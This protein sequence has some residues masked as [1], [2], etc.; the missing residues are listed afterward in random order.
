VAL[1]LRA[2]LLSAL[3]AHLCAAQP[4][5]VAPGVTVEQV[6]DGAGPWEV[7]VIRIERPASQAHLV[8]ALGGGELRGLEALSRIIRR[9]TAD[10]A[11]VVAAV[12]A[13]FF[14]MSGPYAGG[15][16]GPCV[17]NGELVTT[18]RGRPGFFI[19]ADGQPLI[20]TAHT[21]G[22]L[23]VAGRSYPVDGANMPDQGGEGAVQLFT[24]IGGWR[25]GEGC[26]VAALEG[27]PLRTQ[28]SWVATVTEVAPA[29]SARAAG[30]GEVLIAARD[31]Q[32][33]AALLG[34]RPGD[35]VAIELRTPPFTAPVLQAVGGSTVLVQDGAVVAADRVRHPRTAAGY[36]AREI[37]LVTVD[38]RQPRWSV[39]MTMT[40]LAGLMHRL[41]CTDAV[42]LDGGGSTTA[43]AHRDLLGRPSDGRQRRIA[44]ALL[45]V[46]TAPRGDPVA[47][48]VLPARATLLSGAGLPLALRLTDAWHCPLEVESGDIRAEVV[49]QA[50]AAPVTARLDGD[51]LVVEGGPGRA[52]VR[53]AHRDARRAATTVQVEVV[54]RAEAL[55]LSPVDLRLRAGTSAR[56]DARAL[57][58]EGTRLLLPREAITW[59][60]EG[61]GVRHLGGGRFRADGE[62]ARA[63]VTA[64]LDGLAAHARVRS[65][66][67]VPVED[68]ADAPAMSFRGIPETVTG[69]LALLT[70]EHEGR[71]MGFVRMTYDLGEPT[72][73]RAAYVVLDRDLGEALQVSL[74]ARARGREAWVRLLLTDGTGAAHLLTAASALAPAAG[75]RRL[76]VRLPEDLPG[77]VVLGSIYVVAT[78]G[79]AARGEL[80]LA[81]LRALAVR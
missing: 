43:W 46:S 49:E 19:T 25:L 7:R 30:E 23:T 1:L 31:E 44:N 9:E 45:V 53:L 20:A 24:A 5:A 78:A 74:L 54:A 75:W 79:T 2:A 10:D 8:T 73:T 69:D 57:A 52:T 66:V 39:G 15:V 80:D 77:P 38:G 61:E 36:S 63:E 81:D 18:P 4:V 62:G 55:T 17:R 68:F 47:L 67:E 14:R 41:G 58:A 72:R 60:V 29:G 64:T 42:N 16:S 3:C 71:A 70:E 6:R 28:G 65:A 33:R 50:G 34:A 26:V 76:T 32:V 48:R 11:R 37:I 21:T 51:R 35:R 56:I 27:G 12:N 40:E 13:D 22:E 59:R